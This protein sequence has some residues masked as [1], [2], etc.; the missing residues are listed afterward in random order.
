[1]TS[2]PRSPSP[3]S[4]TR[5]SSIFP[6]P[7]IPTSALFQSVAGAAHYSGVDP[8][9]ERA[10]SAR[11]KTSGE[12][13]RDA[14]GIKRRRRN[15][16]VEEHADHSA[17]VEDLKELYEG[18]PT[19]EIFERRWRQDAVF[20][21]PLAKCK[22]MSEIVSQW[23][24]L[25]RVSQ[26]TT[27]GRR[28]ISST[29]S[30]NRVIF[31][32]KQEYVGRLTGKKEGAHHA[33]LTSYLFLFPRSDFTPQVIE[34]IVV[35]DLDEDDKIIRMVDQWQGEEPPKSWGAKYIRRFN[36]KILPWV[37]WLGSGPKT[38]GE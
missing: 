35:V 10:L 4:Q 13:Q 16:I 30:P 24:S 18:R 8:I 1:M 19:M 21:D 23:F 27:L 33:S 28:V 26:S 22:G 15:S 31:W 6:H 37:P 38:N 11:S 2:P 36:A 12:Y 25:S 17:I 7:I 32:Q 20:E 29:R 5:H 9:R 14:R 34:S 3:P